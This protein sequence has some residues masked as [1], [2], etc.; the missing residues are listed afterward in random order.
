[1]KR[2]VSVIQEDGTT[3]IQWGVEEPAEARIQGYVMINEGGTLCVP[4]RGGDDTPYLFT[5]NKLGAS[6]VISE[7]AEPGFG[8]ETLWKMLREE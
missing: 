4:F 2:V 1:M 7:D 6:V 8:T 5:L 3:E